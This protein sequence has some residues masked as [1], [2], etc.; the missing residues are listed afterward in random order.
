MLTTAQKK[1]ENE[2]ENE[3]PFVSINR[4]AHKMRGL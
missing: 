3:D 4:V 2:N 1:D